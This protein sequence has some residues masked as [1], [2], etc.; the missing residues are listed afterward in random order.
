MKIALTLFLLSI[1]SIIYAQIDTQIRFQSNSRKYYVWN[2]EA[3]TYELK[4]TEYENSTIDIREIGSKSNGYVAI[5]MVDNGLARLHHGTITNYSQDNENEGT[6]QMR[7]KMVKAK[8]TYNAKE[9]TITYL[10]DATKERFLRL[11]IFTVAQSE[12]AIEN[13]N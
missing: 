13:N 2:T 5:G 6:W 12:K 4:D 8:I 11:I 3:N 1:S 10:Y 7:S 9:N